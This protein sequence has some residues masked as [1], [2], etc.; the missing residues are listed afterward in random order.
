MNPAVPSFPAPVSR[1]AEPV[2]VTRSNR[3]RFVHLVSFGGLS[4]FVLAV[5]ALY[6]LRGSLS[7]MDHTISDYSLG[8][9]GW[10]M[11][12]AFAAL[13]SGVLGVAV[14]LHFTS[15]PTWWRRAGLWLLTF[16]AV[17]L[18]LDSGYNTDFPG[19]AETFDGAMHGLGMLIICLTLPTASFILG[20]V[21]LH[22]PPAARA[23]WLQVLGIAQLVAIIGFRM[24]PTAWRGLT[25]RVAVALAL[26]AL[27]LLRSLAR[28]PDTGGEEAW[29][30]ELRR[31]RGSTLADHRIGDILVRVRRARSTGSFNHFRD[32][33]RRKSEV[34]SSCGPA[35]Q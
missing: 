25:E 29:P 31:S 3:F 2:L 28:L 14:G 21:F 9:Y 7:P 26:A 4:G 1:Q 35:R 11:R 16:T 12:A 34:P 13:G 6:G 30:S 19:V 5:L 32:I 8:P 23:R 15:P 18:F 20:R 33:T 10:L 17:G 22:D 24:S 27:F